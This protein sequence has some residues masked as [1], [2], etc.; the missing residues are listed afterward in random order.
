MEIFCYNLLLFAQKIEDEKKKKINMKLT[1]V[2]ANENTVIL[3]TTG[4]NMKSTYPHTQI[5]ESQAMATFGF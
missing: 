2:Q 1:H 5:Y 3:T 4:L